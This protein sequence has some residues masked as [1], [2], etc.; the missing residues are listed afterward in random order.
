MTNQASS[1]RALHSLAA[2]YSTR[3]PVGCA[4]LLRETERREPNERHEERLS[5]KNLIQKRLRTRFHV[6]PRVG[7]PFEGILVEEDATYAQFADVVAFPAEGTPERA[8]GDLFIRHAN[9]AYVQ[10]VA[11]YAD[12]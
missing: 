4:T 7:I 9:V 2:P 10:T 1:G 8:D 3:T 11:P 5:R 12:E 6:T